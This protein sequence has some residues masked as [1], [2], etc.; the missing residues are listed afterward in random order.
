MKFEEV[1][2]LIK[3]MEEK[4]RNEDLTIQEKRLLQELKNL[5]IFITQNDKMILNESLGIAKGAC[6]TCGRTY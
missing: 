6:P 3:H 2:K 1:L 4:S 5:M